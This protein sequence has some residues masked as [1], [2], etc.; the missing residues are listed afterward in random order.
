MKLKSIHYSALINL[1][2]YS[3]ERIGFTAE[4]GEDEDIPDVIAVLRQNVR[5]N[6]SLNADKVQRMLYEGRDELENL[7]RKIEK[8]RSEWDAIAEFLRAQGIKPDAVDMPK[9]TNLLP[10]VKA[11]QSGVVDGELEEE[12]EEEEEGEY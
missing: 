12:E 1:G 8:A 11:E 6:A 7:K 2:N 5:N 10:E 3:N 9:F 4:V